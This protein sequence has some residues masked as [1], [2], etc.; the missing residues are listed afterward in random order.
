MYGVALVGSASR[1]GGSFFKTHFTAVLIGIFLAFLTQFINYRKLANCWILIGVV[2]VALIVY[3]LF[4]GVSV[5]GLSG[6]NARAWI[7]L[8]GGLS[9]QPSEIVK[10]GFIITFAKHLSIIKKNQKLNDFKSLFILMLHGLLPALLTHLQG[11]DG[12]ALIFIFIAIF[13]AFIF[14]IE[15]KFFLILIAIF[16]LSVPFIWNFILAPYQKSRI[17]NQFNP[18]GDPLGAGFQQIQSKLSIGSGGLF[19]KGLFCGNRV[20]DGIVPIQES[21]FIFSVAG[22]ETGFVGCL[23]ILILM[24]SLILRIAYLARFANSEPGKTIC[25]GYLGLIAIQCIF[26]IGMCLSL[27]PVIGITLPFFSAGGSSV[28]CLYIGIG[29]V[30]NIYAGSKLLKKN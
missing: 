1:A 7:K 23:L 3:T 18:E 22:E 10:I 4:F 5:V 19:G 14:G 24:T 16:A 15:I 27:L 13:E 2:C 12:A 25:F 21:D 26:N 11:D 20:N 8:P 28:V 9:F 29:I 30:Q 17:I 6:V